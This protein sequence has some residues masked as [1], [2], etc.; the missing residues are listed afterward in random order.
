MN[1]AQLI[2]L[3]E[4]TPAEDL[5][6]EQISLLR[7]RAAE[8]KEMR[9]ALAAHL[10]LEQSLGHVLG[11]AAV[12]VDRIVESRGVSTGRRWRWSLGAAGVLFVVACV[13]AYFV[14]QN[15]GEPGDGDNPAI[16]H[17]PKPGETQDNRPPTT[18]PEEIEPNRDN[19]P[20]EPPVEAPPPEEFRTPWS[21]VAAARAE[22]PA[23][24]EVCFDDFPLQQQGVD[25][26]ELGQW[27]EAASP[28]SLR[29]RPRSGGAPRVEGVAKLRPAW[30]E[31]VALRLALLQPSGFK[32]HVVAGD[33]GVTLQ[34][35]GERWAAYRTTISPGQPLPQPVAL[36]AT[37]E[38][39]FRRSGGGVFA[40]HHH[41][42]QLVLTRGNIRL[43]TAPLP[44]R[45][46]TLRI[47]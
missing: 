44:R 4:N 16:V 41:D 19:R 39:R 28:G 31:N 43:L 17:G 7:S 47:V 20:P 46:A 29:I 34:N 10:Q 5:S 23:F 45:P 1:D 3:F 15:G 36:V 2:E 6:S 22:T 38:G 33:G 26:E 12:S 13:A 14:V 25:V 18:L 11:G 24:A 27:L 9:D 40:M 35:Y 30:R 21:H 37:D 42:G 32:I 8:S